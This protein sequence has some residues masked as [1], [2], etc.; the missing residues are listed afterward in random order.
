MKTMMCLLT[1][2]KLQAKGEST[3]IAIEDGKIKIIREGSL[4]KEE[5]LKV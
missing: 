4:S 1:V 5:I 3:I 2:E